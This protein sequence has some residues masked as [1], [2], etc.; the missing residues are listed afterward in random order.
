MKHIHPPPTEDI[1]KDYLYKWKTLEKYVV[2]ESSI[3]LL[4]NKLCPENKNIE[5]IMLKASVLNDFY[6]T[7]IFDV[8]TVSK[9]ILDCNIDHDLENKDENLVNKIAL[10]DI[11]GKTKN[12]YSFAS[13]YCSHHRPEVYPIYDSYVDK[14]LMY[15][16][17]KDKFYSFIKEDLKKY[18]RFLKIIRKF[19][20][21]YNLENFTLREIDVYLWLAGKDYFQKKYK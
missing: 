7:N 1:I 8:F 2:Q 11:K 12:F 21:H 6:S 9:H 13:K 20:H 18:N 4:F 14:M 19:Q 5:D 16:K 15:F 17:G 3:N 10:V